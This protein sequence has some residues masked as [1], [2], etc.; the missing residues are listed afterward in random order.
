[1]E[2][3]QRV[4]RDDRSIWLGKVEGGVVAVGDEEEAVVGLG[5]GGQRGCNIGIGTEGQYT[6][7]CIPAGAL[8]G[9]RPSGP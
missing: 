3:G 2:R 4:R 5:A 8:P 9:G 1:M 6:V 7:I